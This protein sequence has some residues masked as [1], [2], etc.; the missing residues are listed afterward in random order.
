MEDL[1]SIRRAIEAAGARAA[2]IREAREAAVRDATEARA[3]VAEQEARGAGAEVDALK[4]RAAAAERKIAE[5]GERMADVTAELEAI[6]ARI[7]AAERKDIAES[8]A[9]AA[10][11]EAREAESQAR[12]AEL[13][14]RVA[15]MN[16]ETFFIR[17]ITD[18]PRSFDAWRRGSSGDSDSEMLLQQP[19]GTTR[20]SVADLPLAAVHPGTILECW[21]T[22]RALYRSTRAAGETQQQPRRVSPWGGQV[23]LLDRVIELLVKAAQSH[24]GEKKLRVHFRARVSGGGA[25][26]RCRPSATVVA[27]DDSTLT[28]RSAAAF[29]ER[30]LPGESIYSDR[31]IDI[32]LG[33]ARE[34]ARRGL[35]AVAKEAFIRRDDLSALCVTA[36]GTTGAQIAFARVRLG[37]PGRGETFYNH[38][39][40]TYPSE[41]TEPLPLLDGWDPEADPHWEPPEEPPAGFAALVGLLASPAEALRPDLASAVPRLVS[42]DLRAVVPG[43]PAPQPQP[44]VI[45]LS[46]RLGS[47]GT[48]D[49]FAIDAVEAAEEDAVGARRSSPRRPASTRTSTARTARAS[50]ASSAR[51]S[52]APRSLPRSSTAASR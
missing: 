41:E 23:V 7:A 40:P 8:Q 1:E 34:R 49:I 33:L 47:G 36:V 15:K 6:K 24:A 46:G 42:A 22:F 21:E 28:V 45:R 39:R 26:G 2:A 31:G 16:Q 50:T 37:A 9:R 20:V 14:V 3:A 5:A 13:E 19:N 29:L 18:Q 4:A 35:R 10:E 12:A 30:K 32:A 44:A 48:S 52:A 11:I 17:L 25:G 43:R 51:R 27:A 38:S